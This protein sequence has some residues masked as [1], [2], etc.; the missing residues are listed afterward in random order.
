MWVNNTWR[1]YLKFHQYQISVGLIWNPFIHISCALL[2]SSTFQK[3]F[4]CQRSRKETYS[5][6]DDHV[7]T[8]QFKDTHVTQ[9]IINLKLALRRSSRFLTGT[10]ANCDIHKWPNSM[11][12]DNTVIYQTGSD[13][14]IIRENLQDLKWVEQW[15]ISSRLILN[16]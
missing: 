15:S 11:Y 14:N 1:T 3:Q 2:K 7:K 5:K 6:A 16:H 9:L 10:I 13:I 8:I 12:A 4:H